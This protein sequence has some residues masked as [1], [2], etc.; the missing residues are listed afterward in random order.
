VYGSRVTDRR[1]DLTRV[2]LLVVITAAVAWAVSYAF[3]PMRAG[4]PRA[5][6][7][8]ATTYGVLAAGALAWGW[9]T[10]ALKRWLVPRWGDVSLGFFAA[11]GL[12]GGAFAFVKVIA[13]HGS[14]R[15][16]WM[17]RVYLQL[18]DP[19][20]LREHQAWV[21][22]GIVAFAILEEVVWR[23]WAKSMLD[24]LLNERTGWIASSAL[25][26]LAHVPTIWALADTTVGP[27]PIVFVGALGAGL[28]WA[29]LA[30][31]LGRLGPSIVSHALFDWAV[32]MMFRLWGPSV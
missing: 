28:V 17:A 22:A 26:A 27:N 2:A 30:R 13:S 19:T 3:D 8:L 12:F 5:L 4:E 23:G 16:A 14:P 6:E 1:A 21:G 25:Y 7:A 20:P 29:G 24:D 10:G 15:A 32:L 9:R 11:L 31:V 18:G